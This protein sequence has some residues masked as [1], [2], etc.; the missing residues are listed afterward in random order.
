M[1]G[2][3]SV[4]TYKDFVLESTFHIHKG[5]GSMEGRTGGGN[6]SLPLSSESGSHISH[7]LLPTIQ[8]DR[9]I[10]TYTAIIHIFRFRLKL[11]RNIIHLHTRPPSLS[12]VVMICCAMLCMCVFV[13]SPK[14][15]QH[16]RNH[17]L[18]SLSGIME[19]DSDFLSLFLLLSDQFN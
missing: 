1:G 2:C 15:V 19:C 8:K 14:Q 6:T 16:F 11:S 4:C 9:R 17:S 7:K 13:L 12:G 5:C 18:L 3:G 10:R